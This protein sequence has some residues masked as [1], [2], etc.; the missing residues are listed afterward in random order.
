MAHRAQKSGSAAGGSGLRFTRLEI[1]IG[2]VRARELEAAQVLVPDQPDGGANREFD[3]AQQEHPSSGGGCRGA[4]EQDASDDEPGGDEDVVDDAGGLVAAT[5]EEFAVAYVPVP[6]CGS[7]RFTHAAECHA[8]A[9][10]RV[11]VNGPESAAS[12]VPRHAPAMRSVL[13]LSI[14]DGGTPER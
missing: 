1:L 9:P 8:I 3:A 14:R 6:G 11:R 2:F 10:I 7:C 12:A 13:Q 5:Q 4:E